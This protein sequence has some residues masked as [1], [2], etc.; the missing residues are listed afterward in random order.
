MRHIRNR[1]VL[2]SASTLLAS[3]CGSDVVNP[4]D[5]GRAAF[6]ATVSVSGNAGARSVSNSIKYKDAGVKPAGGRSGSAALEVRAL[7]SKDGSTQVEATTGSLERGT[8]VGQIQKV[9]LKIFTGDTLAT[10][11]NKLTGNG[12]WS[13]SYSSLTRGNE[14]QVQA[15]VGGIDPNRTDVVTVKTAV[16]LRPD[17]SVA[18]VV[19]PRESAPRMPV[20]FTASV[21]ENNGQVGAR[22]NCVLSVDGQDVDQA[23]GIWVDAGGTV[24][25]VFTRVFDTPGTY[26]VGVVATAVDPGDWDTSNN[27]AATSITILEPGQAI[28][29]GYMQGFQIGEFAD[30]RYWNTDGLYPYD[31]RSGWRHDYSYAYLSG[32]DFGAGPGPGGLQRIDAYLFVN[33]SLYN[34]A[35]L[36]PELTHRYNDGD[37]FQECGHFSSYTIDGSFYVYSPNFASWCSF[38]SPSDPAN[39]SSQYNYQYLQ[40]SV[41]YYAR[42]FYCDVYGCNTYSRIEGYMYGPGASLGWIEGTTIR[43]QVSFTDSDGLAHTADRSV[44]FPAPTSENV[45]WQDCWFDDYRRSTGCQS[46]QSTRTLFEGSIGW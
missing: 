5:P 44:T 43:L 36:S 41:V 10:N 12:Y 29:S 46:G 42:E 9:Q 8:Q 23:Q 35:S 18:S 27:R 45:A 39:R 21:S 20:T 13:Q 11:Y 26:S 3:A 31:Q 38:G 40:G 22:S 17:I 1:S 7:L 19:G 16:A 32:Y 4:A 28:R 2:I 34:S 6:R 37:Y 25:C 14:L 33:G 30:I 15:N 24:T